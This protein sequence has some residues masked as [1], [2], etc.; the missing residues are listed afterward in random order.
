MKSLGEMIYKDNW[1]EKK[2]END[3]KLEKLQEKS[4]ALQE[5]R[6]IK[7]G[8][9]IICPHCHSKNIQFMQQDKKGFSVG[10]AVGG[11]VLAGGVGTM[12]GFAGK[13]GKNQWFCVDCNRTFLTKK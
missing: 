6:D 7:S 1:E 11:A 3:E 2:K 9:I 12:A 4:R 13:K 5:I 10:K 8:K